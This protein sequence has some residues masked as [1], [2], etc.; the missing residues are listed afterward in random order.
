MNI[1]F[2]SRKKQKEIENFFKDTYGFE[3]PTCKII[4]KGKDKLRIFTGDI[5]EHEFNI[6]SHLLR[7]EIAGMYLTFDKDNE[8]RL[9]Y[10][11]SYLAKNAKNN[12]FEVNEK[13]FKLWMSGEDIPSTK[14]F[15]EK[16]VL[17]KYKSDIIGCGK[18]T[19]EK[20]LNFVPKERRQ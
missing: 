7:I 16:F 4:K 2:L 3:L 10:D 8:T 14:K 12:L 9:S 1:Q 18:A 5:S 15:K 13:Q 17:I 20:I 11:A 19:Q 6:L